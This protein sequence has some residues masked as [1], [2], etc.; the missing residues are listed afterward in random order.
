M[1]GKWKTGEYNYKG[2]SKQLRVLPV[3]PR[4]SALVDSLR[5]YNEAEG[6]QG[7]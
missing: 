6:G 1:K 4:L 7:E 3:T 5:E 2:K